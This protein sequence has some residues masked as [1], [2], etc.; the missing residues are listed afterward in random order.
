MIPLHQ[1]PGDRQCLRY[2]VASIFE[3]PVEKVPF[4]GMREGIDPKDR[5]AV[6]V[7]YDLH[8]WLKERGLGFIEVYADEEGKPMRPIWGLCV[9]RGTTERGTYHA[10]VWDAGHWLDRDDDGVGRMVHDPHPSNAG[11]TKIESWWCFVV[12]DPTKMGAL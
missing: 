9:G 8:A 7:A 5:R 11:L 1:T 4:F 10:V 3:L 2:A 6:D 12:R